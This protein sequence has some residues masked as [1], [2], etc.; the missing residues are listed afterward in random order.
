MAQ[1]MFPLPSDTSF[2]PPGQGPNPKPYLPPEVQQL[3]TGV[4]YLRCTAALP[5]PAGPPEALRGAKVAA[6]AKLVPAYH[7]EA[8]SWRTHRHQ[9]LYHCNSLGEPQLPVS[10]ATSICELQSLEG[11]QHHSCH[12]F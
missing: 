4:A 10:R 7:A 5:L 8:P 11:R 9:A 12:L 6:Q 1:T 2:Q 3:H